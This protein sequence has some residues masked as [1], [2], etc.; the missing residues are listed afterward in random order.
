MGSE[1]DRLSNPAEGAMPAGESWGGSCS[2][3][4]LCNTTTNTG[5]GG[6]KAGRGQS[7]TR[8]VVFY[9]LNTLTLAGDKGFVNRTPFSAKF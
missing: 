8:R 6:E 1:R 3:V 2:F 7:A 4:L 9:Q 5:G